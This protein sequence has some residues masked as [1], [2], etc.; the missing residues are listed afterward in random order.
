LKPCI[1][2]KTS[3]DGELDYPAWGIS[4]THIA[5]TFVTRQMKIPAEGI[6]TQ[7]DLVR[8]IQFSAGTEFQE[9]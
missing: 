7:N 2:V 1:A 5:R 4:S 9:E 8:W 3:H 6:Q